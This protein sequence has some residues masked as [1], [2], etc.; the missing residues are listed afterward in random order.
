MALI[1]SFET[2]RLILRPVRMA[3]LGAYQTH[4]VCWEV[5]SELSAGVPWPYPQDGVADFMTNHL[6]PAQGVSSWSWAIVL[7]ESDGEM[8]GLVELW[9]E[10]KP[11]NRGFWLGK[12]YWGRGLM[13]EAVE[14]VMD[15]AFEQLGFDT[16]VF[17]NARGNSRSRRVKEKT[18]A[19]LVRVEPASF[20]N[21]AYSEREVWELTKTEWQSRKR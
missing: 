1:P 21:P 7:K 20:V 19:R 18:G 15:Y 4:F 17:S 6:L 5:I 14:P 9:R 16:L 10:G 13:T 3:D 2:P 8:I 11:E 12:R